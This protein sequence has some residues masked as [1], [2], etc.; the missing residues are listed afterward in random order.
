M[1]LGAKN[2][3]CFGVRKNLRRQRTVHTFINGIDMKVKVISTPK[4]WYG[5]FQGFNVSINGIK[6][7]KNCLEREQAEIKAYNR[8]FDS[9]VNR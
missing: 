8:Y 6:S 4:F 2:N 9:I 1:S 7:F 5:N 3:K